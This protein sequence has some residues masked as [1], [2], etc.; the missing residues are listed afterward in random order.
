MRKLPR[1]NLSDNITNH[2]TPSWV[3]PVG[4]DIFANQTFNFDSAFNNL[5][6][7]TRARI[8]TGISLGK[9]HAEQW[10]KPLMKYLKDVHLKHG[11]LWA[12]AQMATKRVTTY[13]RREH[14]A[15]FYQEPEPC[16]DDLQDSGHSCFIC[17][18]R[19]ACH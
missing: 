19:R 6:V 7:Q 9:E 10:S 18:E 12:S 5:S 8:F 3:D 16:D 17:A 4:G 11:R 13:R 14:E 15:I 1:A 2:H